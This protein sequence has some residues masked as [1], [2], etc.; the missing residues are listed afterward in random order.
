MAPTRQGTERGFDRLIFFSDAV[1]AIAITLLIL[2]VVDSV[3]ADESTSNLFDHGGPR[4]GAFLLSFAVIAWFWILHHSLF[5]R[6]AGYNAPLVWANMLW[7]ASIV[8]LPVP[9]ELVGVRGTDEAKV[10]FLYIGTVLLSSAGLL[11]IDIVLRSSP[12]LWAADATASDF[13]LVPGLTAVMVLIVALIIGTAIEPIGMWSLALLLLTTPFE[14]WFRR[15]R[16]G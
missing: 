5:E 9:T 6:V 4:I 16:G 12:D 15:R 7:L 1:V 11:L 14:R 2:P 3:S 13:S 8:F 10:R